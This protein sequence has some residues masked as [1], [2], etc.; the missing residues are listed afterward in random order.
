MQ[1]RVRY[2]DAADGHRIEPRNRR[3]RAGTADLDVDALTTVV[4]CS[5]GNLCAI[6]Q[7]GLRETNQAV[8]PV[9][10]VDFIDHAVDVI[11][12]RRARLLD[13]AV[14]CEQ[15]ARRYGRAHQRIDR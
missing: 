7:R 14:E 8:L 12:E 11:A 9:E 1:R 4:A 10:A 5:A 6:A 15:L 3:Q 13:L 2:H